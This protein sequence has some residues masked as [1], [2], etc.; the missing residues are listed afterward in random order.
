[1]ENMGSENIE[2]AP[3]SVVKQAARGFAAA[4]A[5]TPQF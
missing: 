1:M 2:I 4:L 3:S 5:E